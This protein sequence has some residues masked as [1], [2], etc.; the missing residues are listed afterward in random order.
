MGME[1][2][3]L[4]RSGSTPYTIWVALRP[5][6]KFWWLGSAC[7]AGALPSSSVTWNDHILAHMFLYLQHQS[8]GNGSP[9]TGHVW[10]Y[11]IHQLGGPAPGLIVGVVWVRQPTPTTMVEGGLG[12]TPHLLLTNDGPQHRGASSTLGWTGLPLCL[13]CI[14]LYL[15][16]CITSVMGMEQPSRVKSG[17]TP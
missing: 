1:P 10:L 16:T 4:V 6:S 13:V 8:D 9:F 14:Y 12:T 3:S 17:S 11:T 7:Q 2:P 15:H 5:A